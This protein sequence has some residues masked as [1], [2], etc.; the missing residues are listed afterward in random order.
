MYLG[1]I[2]FNYHWIFSES[3]LPFQPCSELGGEFW[4]AVEKPSKP[5]LS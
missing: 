2:V 4:V 3:P 1:K 5:V